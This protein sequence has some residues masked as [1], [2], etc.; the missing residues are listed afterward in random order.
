MIFHAQI[1]YL[2]FLYFV[3]LSNLINLVLRLPLVSISS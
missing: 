2:V 3:G 1:C